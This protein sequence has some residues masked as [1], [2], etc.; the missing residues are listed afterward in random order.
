MNEKQIIE[1]FKVDYQYRLSDGVLQKY[2]TVVTRFLL[3]T[4]KK[5]GDIKSKDIRDWMGNWLDQGYKPGTVY[6]NLS[7]L[8]TF[9]TYCVEE[10]LL[11]KSPA[12]DVRFPKME[13]KLPR[14]LT[15]EQLAR[16][17]TLTEGKVLDR[18]IVEVLYTTGI[19]VV[20]MVNMK[21]EDINWDERFITIPE[22]K[23]KTERIVMFTREC[24]EYLQLHLKTTCHDSPYVFVSPL[25]SPKPYATDSIRHR[26]EGYSK[27][28]GFKITPHLLRH[29]FAAHLAQKN[30]PVEHIQQLLGHSSLDTTRIYARL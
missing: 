5:L 20:E 17:R 18:A 4:G 3:Y 10:G 23:G 1:Q 24:A 14:Y 13:E 16:L 6:N 7:G 11:D 8:K 15:K 9:F 26:F 28:L 22:A 19:R 25:N 30:M 12:Q 29:T 27:Q 21:R 2:Q